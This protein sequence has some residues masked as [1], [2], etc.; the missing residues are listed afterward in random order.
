MGVRGSDPERWVRAGLTAGAIAGPL[1]AATA[2]VEGALRPDY[3]PI[4]HP[5]SSLA[6][7]P[8]RGVQIANFLLTGAL[9]AGLAVGLSR[10]R[11]E[12]DRSSVMPMLVGSSAAGLV[13][14]GLFTADPVSGYPIGTPDR[15]VPTA[16]GTLHNLA[17]IPLVVGVTGSAMVEARHS[18][19]RGEYVWAALSAA[20]V[21]L[22]PFT[23]VLAGAGFAQQPRLVARAGLM[24]RISVGTALGWVTVLAIRR[25]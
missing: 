4:R 10:A 8:R 12:D 11:D 14:S 24:Q 15:A 9:Y 18:V 21:V 22:M 6:F 1:F 16:V 2:L 17:A 19:K 7:G 13:L 23:F 25:R 20:V 3:H 5:I